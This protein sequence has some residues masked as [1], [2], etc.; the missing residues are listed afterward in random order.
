MFTHLH[1]HTQYSLLEGA[2][3][4]K[5]LVTALKSHGFESCAVTDH[6]NM[7]GVVEFYHALKKEGLKPIIG[8][9]ANVIESDF[10]E[11]SSE[12]GVNNPTTGQTQFL[13]QNR[14]G[15]QN[16]GF[17]VS[18]SFTEGKL[19]GV[20]SFRHQLL[21]KYNAGL[22]ALSGGMGGGIN[23]YLLEGRP[24]E[25][26]RLA[27]WYRDVFAGRYYLELQNTGLPEQF[28]LN[29]QLINLGHEL[30]IPLVGTN[31]CLYLTPEEAEAQYI[32]W[33][34]GLQRRVTDD[35]V[36][37][38]LGNQRYLKSPEEM[39]TAFAELPLI[40]LENTSKI[41]EQCELSL[42]NDK[43]YLPQISTR[44]EETLDS[45]LRDDAKN[46]LELRLKKLFKLYL[47]ESTFEEFQKPYYERLSFELDVIIQMKF[48]GYFLIVS[49]FIKWSK[50]NGVTVGPGRG[51]GAGSLVAY[52]LLITDVDPLRY[53]L[54]FERFLNP[55]R[56]NLPD[57]DIDFDVEGREKVIEHVR[58]K[59]GEKNV[60][61]ISTFGSLKAKAVVRGV[62]RVLDFPYSEADKIAKLIPNDLNITLDQALAK[63]PELA[64]LAA[65]G[66]ENEQRLI[67]FS[68][69]LEDLN[70]HLGT[71]A[72]GVIIMDQ[73]I[74]EVMPV[75]T[76]K[77]G[78]LQSMYPMKYAEDQGAVKFDFLGL[79][80]LSTIDNTLELIKKSR[81]QA[82]VL[83]IS[84]IPMDD[85][86]TFDL[87]CK[88]DTIGV[89]Q[90]ESSG[91]KRLVANMQPSVFEDIVAILALYRPGPLGSGMVEDYVQCKH[92]RKRV[93]YPHPLM[94]EILRETYGV[95]VYQE[96]IIQGV[97]VLAGFSLGQAD[98]LRRAIGKKTPEVL[99]EQR[100]QFVEGC[101]KNPE[102]VEQC[103]QAST[104]EEKANEIF[105]TINYF[106]GYGFNKS[107]SVAYGLISYQTAY[108]KAH[109]PV[110][111]MAALFNG[112]INNQDNIISYISE[113]KAMGIKVLPP[114]VN[115]SEKTFT[116]AATE[117]R[118][119]AIT[120]AHFER[121][122]NAANPDRDTVP[123]DM[124]EHLKT[125][126]K[127]LKNQNF[128]EQDQLLNLLA[129][130]AEEHYQQ[131]LTQNLTAE[132]SENNINRIFEKQSAFAAWLQREARVEVIRFGL[133]AV[134]NVGGKAVDAIL[135]VRNEHGQLTDFM[136]F[137][138]KIDLKE[139]NKRMFE[140]LVKCGA[141]DSLHENRAQLFSTLESAFHLAQ[142]FRRA[143]DP[144]QDSL[145]G[146]MDAGDAEATETQL[147]FPEVRN[148]P[149]KERL[150]QE[151]A[152]LGFYVS[153]HPLDSFVSEIK[154]LA[155]TTAKLKD[156]L[157]AERD[158]VSLVGIIVN[159]TVR[160]NQS[161][162]KF[163][164]VTLEDTRGTIEFPVFAAVYEKDGE[165]LE[166][167]EPL[168]ISGRVN[169]RDEEVSLF[170]DQ[171]HRLNEIRETEAK[172]MSINIAAE[173]LDSAKI[174]LL[175]N[176][177]QKYAG[178]K[179]FTFSVQT[180]E[181][182]SVTITPEEK[183]NF[184]SA[185][186]EELEELLPQQ[187]LEFGY[188][189]LKNIK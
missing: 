90:L 135:K 21:E 29:R 111:L 3:R 48:P 47:P 168:L 37:T 103:P 59:Y 88:A 137:M 13:C 107:H 68:R 174:N 94:A 62:A 77:D 181:A 129:K 78:S 61:Q 98:L 19:R 110:Q 102:F 26:R 70:T 140:T 97:Q 49:E 38:Q 52:A 158:K 152:A 169:Y 175:R 115:H 172:N 82:T 188:S 79:Q 146:L 170:V 87:F 64:L 166:S 157:H 45:K 165:L 109:Y 28:E 96:Q 186:I 138:K 84:S 179:P 162:A 184:T 124:L 187:T 72:A 144:A 122:F 153:G 116:V 34:M 22:I 126:L 54:L 104:P 8:M 117:F 164:I 67:K 118:I 9:G 63:E 27:L 11:S 18:L 12:S 106:S 113:C 40:A 2:I 30:D 31:D 58:D 127:S 16:L 143:E 182:T 149:K 125:A 91:M 71:H 189:S 65:E 89:F 80:N 148:W 46:G 43:L 123:E 171:I 41:A 147:E 180:P 155:T 51:S 10:A 161:N 14:Q 44:E 57:F 178:E 4:I 42:E 121:D 69:Q 20:P 50:E 95:L 183:L 154:L 136:D 156:G 128:K 100:I 167:S 133:N 114:D 39:F 93:V 7:F 5:D 150:N 177:L 119:S 73:D 23:R 131:L 36:P 159:N 15:Y 25:A 56:V 130:T 141:F 112:S 145:F 132:I 24:N 74:R 92:G 1:L 86:L 142:E 66:S 53:G 75:C 139:V 151:K 101:L 76:G 85:P 60:C 160:L 17:L 176:T 105:D 81:Q 120:L 108:L 185:L 33:L 83:D 173:K 35:G 6:G 99:A 134:K 32:L 55:Y 163:A